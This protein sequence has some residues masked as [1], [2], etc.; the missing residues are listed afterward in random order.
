MLRALRRWREEIADEAGVPLHYILNND[1]L[2]ELARHRPTTREELLTIKGIGPV[3]AERFG[4]TLLEIVAAARAARRG[5]VGTKPARGERELAFPILAFRPCFPSFPLLDMAV[6][7]GRFS[8]DECAAIR[9]LSR[10]VVCS[11]PNRPNAIPRAR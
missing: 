10:E 9:G 6:V 2:A 1:T 11:T 5:T 3:K 7:I 8:V 4:V